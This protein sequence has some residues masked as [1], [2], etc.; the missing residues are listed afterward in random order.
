MTIDD[1]IRQFNRACEEGSVEGVLE[2]NAP[3]DITGWALGP[4]DNYMTLDALSREASDRFESIE[5][6]SLEG[7]RDKWWFGNEQVVCL[8][9]VFDETICYRSGEVSHLKGVRVT[10]YL[11]KHHGSWLIRHGH[12]SLPCGEGRRPSQPIPARGAVSQFASCRASGGQLEVLLSWLQRC[13]DCLRKNDPERA[14]NDLLVVDDNVVYWRLSDASALCSRQAFLDYWRERFVGRAMDLQFQNP[15]AYVCLP[16]ACLSAD[17]T[18]VERC[19]FSGEVITVSP[20][21]CTFV[22]EQQVG[23][24]R[25]RHIHFSVPDYV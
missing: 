7:M 10:W 25:A 3:D 15:V 17:A 2:V 19:L 13:S 21:R 16:Y 4:D 6:R 14:L 20:V 9:Y 18:L 23:H 5:T 12:W 24:W 22:M 8:T 1:F 11:E